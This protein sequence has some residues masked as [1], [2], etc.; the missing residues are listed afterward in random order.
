MARRS[1][2]A[3]LDQLNAHTANN[4]FERSGVGRGGAVLAI[5]WVLGG[6]KWR[7]AGRSTSR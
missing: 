1:G 3:A 6:A 4:E 2:C 5:D 7:R